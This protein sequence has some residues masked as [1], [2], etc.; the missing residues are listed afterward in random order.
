[1]VFINRFSDKNHQE[2]PPCTKAEVC[3]DIKLSNIYKYFLG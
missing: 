2:Q 1:M 3:H